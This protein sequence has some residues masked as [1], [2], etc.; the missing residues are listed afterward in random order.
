MQA[1]QYTVRRV[2]P[3]IDRELRRLARVSKRSLNEVTLEVLQAGLGL[4]SYDLTKQSP[5]L[6]GLAAFD[7]ASK[8]PSRLDPNKPIKQLYHESL[9]KKY[10]S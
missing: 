9:T 8:H 6:G 1:K 3:V 7:R 5:G 10:E 2:H 4:H